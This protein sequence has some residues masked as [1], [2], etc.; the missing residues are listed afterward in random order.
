VG[1]AGPHHRPGRRGARGAARPGG[2]DSILIIA[3]STPVDLPFILAAQV[4]R[5]ILVLMVGPWA[6]SRV[7]RWTRPPAA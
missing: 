7:A 6:A 2:V 4:T 5:I 1:A 3:A